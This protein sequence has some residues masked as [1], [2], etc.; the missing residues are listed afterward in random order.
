MNVLNQIN[1]FNGLLVLKEFGN[2][3]ISLSKTFIAMIVLIIYSPKYLHLVVFVCSAHFPY[4]TQQ[5]CV[6]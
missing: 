4:F 1:L 6:V 2:I 5:R 3:I